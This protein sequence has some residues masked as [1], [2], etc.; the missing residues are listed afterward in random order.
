V[1]STAVA[2]PDVLTAAAALLVA[3]AAVLVHRSNRRGAALLRALV[4]HSG[5]AIA[6]VAGDGRVKAALGATE[7]VLGRRADALEGARLAELVHGEDVEA[8]A[9]L[10]GPQPPQELA[11]RLRLP[12]GRHRPVTATVADLREDRVV[13]G[14]V[15]RLRDASERVERESQLRDQALRDPLTGLPNR[16]LF[17]DRI[18][19]ALRRAGRD[20]SLVAVA[21]VDLD[22]FKGINDTLGHAAG[23]ELLVGV[24][25]R[26]RTTLRGMDTAARFG[27]D[28]FAVLVGGIPDQA[29]LVRIADR[30]LAALSEP[31]E[32][33]GEQ[34]RVAPSIGLSIGA[35][36]ATAED[37]LRQADAA[38]YAAK[39]AGKGRYELHVGGEAEAEDA[40]EPVPAW[41][42]RAEDERS[43][44]LA[45]LE[46]PLRPSLAPI[47]DLRS[48]RIAGH[49]AIA[50]FDVADPRPAAAWLAQARRSGLG[51]RL[52]AE[53]VRAALAIPGR[54]DR[55][56]LAVNVALYA[57]DSADLQ[58]A[59]P[60][61]LAG[62]VLEL[63]EPA[64]LAAGEGLE[65]SLA[66]LRH[67]GAKLAIDSAGAG[68][69]GLR[70]LMRLR[71]DLVKLDR[72]LVAGIGEDTAAQ[73]LV[74]SFVRLARSFQAEVCADGVEAPEDLRVLAK[75][76]VRYAQ[77]RA[78][79][80]A[81]EGW[82]HAT[83]TAGAVA[84]A[85]PRGAA[86]G[87]RRG[88]IAPPASRAG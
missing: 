27:G 80:P 8:V 52:E 55:T 66:R 73:T 43:E 9:Q 67:R 13:V 36:D 54:P 64:L 30:L 26:L 49:E 4:E 70:M 48:G 77:G 28:E 38:M 42:Q 40:A 20:D 23:D 87:P 71:P 47:V 16:A 79:A 10:D 18:D 53:V 62:L 44:V 14:L 81:R 29:E 76:D 83:A 7:A 60:S 78:V 57:L 39:R 85:H 45:L 3:L 24:A 56:F 75:L 17:T 37:L 68:Y 31:H 6:I 34:R 51:P 84:A 61:D 58:A 65:Q 35:A 63:D 59:L 15:L 2:I 1:T 50:G 69:A 11:L 74:E 25:D 33:A 46:R 21:F 72:G 32:L 86:A 88:T 41:F 5:D 19:H 22:D 82:G 12:S